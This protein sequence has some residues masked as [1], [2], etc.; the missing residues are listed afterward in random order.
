MSTFSFIAGNLV[1]R[2][3]NFQY[4]DI[5]AHYPFNPNSKEIA[6]FIQFRK[7]FIKY[8]EKTPFLPMNSV[9]SKA[10]GDFRIMR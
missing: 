4:K 8:E 5:L 1:K 10:G 3:F 6:N 2:P 9:L 7:N